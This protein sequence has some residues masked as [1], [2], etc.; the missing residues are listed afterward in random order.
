MF[1]YTTFIPNASVIKKYSHR[2]KVS[3]K[4]VKISLLDMHLGEERCYEPV[5]TISFKDLEVY[6]AIKFLNSIEAKK[7]ATRRSHEELL[8][9]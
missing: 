5:D 7:T 9:T 8:F 4:A 1:I 2:K 3:L 6:Y